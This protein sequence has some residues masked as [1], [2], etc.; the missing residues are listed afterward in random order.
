MERILIVDDHPMVRDGLCFMVSSGLRGYVPVEASSLNEAMNAIQ[1]DIEIELVLLDLD[2]PGSRGLSGLI[3]LR[4]RF[5]WVPVV[6]V[7]ASQETG[8]ARKALSAG[9]AGFVSKSSPREEIVRALTDVLAGG[10]YAP[11]GADDGSHPDEETGQIARRIATLT[12]QQHVVLQLIV[13]GKLNKQIAYDLG[14]SITTVKAHVSAILSK[15]HVVSRTQ[16]A[17]LA[18]KFHHGGE[19]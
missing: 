17:M 12:P 8:L 3:E 19:P 10:I 4:R 14:V 7:S 11:E 18:S 15:L 5:P 1:Q 16:A 9:A 2:I 6:I 13:A